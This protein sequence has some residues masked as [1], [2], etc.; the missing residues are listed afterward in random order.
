MGKTFVEHDKKVDFQDIIFDLLLKMNYA[1]SVGDESAYYNLIEHL[2][3]IMIPYFDDRYEK[4]VEE[5]NKKF[6]GDIS[7]KTMLEI[8][9]KREKIRKQKLEAKLGALLRLARRA[10]LLPSGGYKGK[11]KSNL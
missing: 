4:E 11:E 8:T 2:E 10:N 7:G 9:A 3:R 6:N 5:I 1:V